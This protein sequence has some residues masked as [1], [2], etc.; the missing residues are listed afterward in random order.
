VRRWIATD[1]LPMHRLGRQLRI[2]EAKLAAFLRAEWLPRT[3]IKRG[4]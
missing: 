1:D 2:S 4:A 3:L